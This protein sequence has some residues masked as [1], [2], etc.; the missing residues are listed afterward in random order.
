MVSALHTQGRLLNR[1]LAGT[2]LAVVAWW[3]GLN[4]VVLQAESA[5]R[6]TVAGWVDEARLSDAAR[7]PGQW[8][9]AGRDTS[10]AY[11]SPLAQINRDN[12][13]TLGFAWEYRLGT[14]RGL[15]A[16]PLVVDGAMYVS[17]NWAVVYALEAAT[18]AHH[19]R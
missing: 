6:P 7:E 8:F 13:K 9:T 2:L 4:S 3:T 15:E 11:Y 12:V 16:T 18:G 5:E 10:S 17:G 1:A 19:W 14:Y